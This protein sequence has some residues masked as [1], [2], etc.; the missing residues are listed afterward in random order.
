[1]VDV[2]TT[3]KALATI[4]LSSG[5]TEGE[6][7]VLH[8][9][10]AVLQKRKAKEGEERKRLAEERKCKQEEKKRKER[11]RLRKDEKIKQVPSRKIR[12]CE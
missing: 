12:I 2:S 7:N 10:I 11:K 1:M 3:D 4:D 6:L 8:Q 9:R 5:S